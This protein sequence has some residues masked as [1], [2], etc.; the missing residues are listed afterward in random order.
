MRRRNRSSI[1]GVTARSWR[2]AL[3]ILAAISGLALAAPFWVGRIVPLLDLPQHLAVVTVL[4]HPTDPAWGFAPFFDTQWRKLTPY[5][6][7]YAITCLL[8]LLVPVET[9]SRLYL[10]GYAMAFPFAG[11]ALCRGFGRSPWLG[12]LA[13][14]LAFNT[15]LYFG[16]INY[17]TGVLL[18]LWLAADFER[19]LPAGAR[20]RWARHVFVA[21][22]LFFTHVQA[23]AFYVAVAL[24]LAATRIDVAPRRRLIAASVLLPTTLGLLVPWLWVQTVAPR[25]SG[26]HYA[27]G[28]VGQFGAAF[29]PV[30]QAMRSLPEA[31]AG[32]YQDKTDVWLLAAWLLL[33]VWAL[34]P[35][36]GDDARPR[37]G[38]GLL[39]LL[40]LL[41]Y[42]AAPV[43]V[44]GQ[45]NIGPRFA[46][47]AAL[48]LLPQARAANGRAVAIGVAAVALTVATGLNAAREHVLF[49]REAGAFD[50]AIDAI[51]RGAR[52][53]PLIFDNRG[54][55]LERWP[56]LHIG[57]YSM[58]RRGGVSAANLGR[59]E[60]FPIRLRNAQA[61]PALDPFRPEDFRFDA[62]APHYDCILVRDPSG[63]AHERFPPGT[64]RRFDR[65][66]WTVYAIPEARR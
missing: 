56:Y 37:A 5:W 11:I 41:A 65:A 7:H 19:G 52:V 24:V 1:G 60:P 53:L 63:A 45:W 27:F 40:A 50:Q 54:H 3:P 57:Q 47:L 36:P 44:T 22:L 21:L 23:F 33:L 16:F 48:F 49:D 42:F 51:P 2:P 55:V 32:S 46:L 66:G 64:P 34:W 17:C 58:V 25:Q 43:A 12:L 26:G 10:T 8:S 61:L 18:V 59:Y 6:M 9:A 35:R 15:N 4:R 14:P 62:I 38:V 31:L 13:A 29:Q 30:S 20:F 39:P 28:R